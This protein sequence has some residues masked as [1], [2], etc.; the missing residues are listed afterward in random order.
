MRP[1][2]WLARPGGRQRLPPAW[3]QK[4]S[5]GWQVRHRAL[6]SNLAAAH[7]VAVLSLATALKRSLIGQQK[8]TAFS[9]AADEVP[10][11]YAWLGIGGPG[12]D[13]GLH[14]PTFRMDEAQL[15][16]G[17]ALHAAVALRALAQ[18]QTRRDA[19]EL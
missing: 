2:P 8:L 1:R 4:I 12:T 7:S 15:P 11:A 13:S 3:P 9:S 19:S 5:P 18:Q 10:G 17:A 6:P 14:T 16:T